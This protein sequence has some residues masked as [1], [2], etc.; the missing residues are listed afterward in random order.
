MRDDFS[1]KHAIVLLDTRHRLSSKHAVTFPKC[2]RMRVR[3]P[4]YQ[5]STTAEVSAGRAD[6]ERFRGVGGVAFLGKSYAECGDSGT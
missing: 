4:K 3:F 5:E 2:G 1:T 6:F